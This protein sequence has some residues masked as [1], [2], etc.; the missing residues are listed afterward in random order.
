ML[1]VCYRGRNGHPGRTCPCIKKPETGA[2]P[3]YSASSC[4]S[5]QPQFRG[6][7]RKFPRHFKGHFS[8]G[9]VQVRILPSQ[10]AIPAIGQASRETRK[11]AGNPGFSRI[12]FRL[13][14]SGWPSWRRKSTKVSGHLREY[15]RFRETMGGD[16]FDHDCRPTRALCLGAV[17]HHAALSSEPIAQSTSAITQLNGN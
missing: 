5:L 2:Y 9:N 4:K 3:G 15:S 7:M 16:R 12:H 6:K 1:D 11:R 8:I 17:F 14:T 13:W 10:P